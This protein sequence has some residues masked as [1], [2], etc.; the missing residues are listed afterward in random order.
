MDYEV[1]DRIVVTVE[2]ERIITDIK[3]HGGGTDYTYDRGLPAGGRI[4][5]DRKIGKVRK[6]K[7]RTCFNHPDVG[8]EHACARC[9]TGRPDRCMLLEP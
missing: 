4:V 8:K 5:G 1:G 2:Y 9:R 6:R 7:A 3:S